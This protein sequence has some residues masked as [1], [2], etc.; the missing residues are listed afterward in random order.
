MKKLII[1]SFAIM[2]LS[3]L[4][5]PLMAQDAIARL[6]INDVKTKHTALLNERAEKNFR[7][8]FR[9]VYS[10]K[11]I[12]KE[13][14]Y[15]VKFADGEV[16]YMVDYNKRGNWVSTISNYNEEQLDSH[17]ANAVKTAFLG[18]AIV[19]VTEVKKGKTT[20]Y[21][22]KIDNQKL[23]KTVR[24]VNGEIDVFESYIKS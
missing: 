22:V 21:L 10:P 16:K 24:V 6:N 12:E 18:Y 2:Q 9:N 14:G 13:D 20:V 4:G 8:D 11:W 5:S 1:I 19:H 17:I 23:L 7:R 3:S 15:R